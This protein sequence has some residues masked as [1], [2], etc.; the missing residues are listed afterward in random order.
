MLAVNSPRLAP[1]AYPMQRPS[2][3]RIP[4]TTEGMGLSLESPAF[5]P[6]NMVRVNCPPSALG[7]PR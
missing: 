5:L 7:G 1:F 3:L 4:S 2:L 6:M